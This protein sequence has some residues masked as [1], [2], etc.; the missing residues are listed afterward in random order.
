MKLNRSEI[1][2]LLTVASALVPCVGIFTFYYLLYSMFYRTLWRERGLIESIKHK[3][4][5]LREA[6]YTLD[7]HYKI[8]KYKE[9]NPHPG[10]FVLPYAILVF[11][12]DLGVLFALKSIAEDYNKE[13]KNDKIDVRKALS[14][15]MALG[16]IDGL[17]L[18]MAGGLGYSF[19]LTPSMSLINVLW[20]S[21][22]ISY[23]IVVRSTLSTVLHPLFKYIII[24]WC[25]L[26][27]GIIFTFYLNLTKR[28]EEAV[29]ERSKY[30]G[31]LEED[32]YALERLSEIERQLL[33]EPPLIEN[34]VCPNCGAEIPMIAR[35]CPFC[36]IQLDKTKIGVRRFIK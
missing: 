4:E 30:I 8:R 20:I 28:I 9:I 21:G 24:A 33:A 26:K 22:S 1:T 18:G 12:L 5:E 19:L 10:K 7:I 6:G 34:A 25:I 31:E 3:I 36:G 16:L 17:I 13:V 29:T 2:R 32:L 11:V 23:L 35:Y 15:L 27:S 14:L